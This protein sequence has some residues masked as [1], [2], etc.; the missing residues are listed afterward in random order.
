MNESQS[1]IRNKIQHSF[2]KQLE[3]MKDLIEEYGFVSGQ[4]NA[5]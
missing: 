3:E 1:I 4:V 2:G 5:L